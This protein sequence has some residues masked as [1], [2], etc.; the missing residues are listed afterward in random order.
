MSKGEMRCMALALRGA[1]R[2][3]RTVGGTPAMAGGEGWVGAGARRRVC[4]ASA[5]ARRWS[6]PV[7]PL[8]TSTRSSSNSSP[9]LH[10]LLPAP[11]AGLVL[12]P[13]SLHTQSLA[14]AARS[15]HTTL[16]QADAECCPPQAPRPQVAHPVAATGE[17]ELRGSY[18]SLGGFDK[19]YVV[20]YYGLRDRQ[21]TTDWPGRG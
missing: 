21:L 18:E 19:V 15:F 7:L 3:T 2:A 8:S 10:A 16:T 17:Y 12:Q 4:I 13:G 14:P 6:G 5:S 9:K 1:A 11:R 20:S